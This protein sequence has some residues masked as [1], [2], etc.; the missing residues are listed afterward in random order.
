MIKNILKKIKPGY[1]SLEVVIIG[2][3]IVGIGAATIG[4]F[5][6]SSLT[7]VNNSVNT[8]S[9]SIDVENFPGLT[10]KE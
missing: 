2:G 1:V 8:I 5:G 7:Q 10:F 4:L 9:S 3:L 6:D